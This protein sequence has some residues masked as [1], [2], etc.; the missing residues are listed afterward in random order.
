MTLTISQRMTMATWTL[1]QQRARGM[2]KE[3]LKRQAVRP[4][5]VAAKDISSWAQ[6]YLEDH[7][8]LIAEAKLVVDG[9]HAQGRF[10]PRGGFR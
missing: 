4:S 10:G 5:E 9:W 7:P 8:E 6:V 3:A 2:V 1:P